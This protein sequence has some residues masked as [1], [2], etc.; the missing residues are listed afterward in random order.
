MRALFNGN[1]CTS[2]YSHI[3]VRDESDIS[4]LYDGLSLLARHNVLMTGRNM[5]T[6]IGKE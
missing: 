2:F 6:P 4:T 1:P 3:N 5:I